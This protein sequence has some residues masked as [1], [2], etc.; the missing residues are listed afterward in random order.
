MAGDP[1]CGVQ[2]ESVRPLVAEGGG[3]LFQPPPEA[4]PPELGNDFVS[5]YANSFF[6]ITFLFFNYN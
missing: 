6:K 3:G 2:A 5:A 1:G 4:G